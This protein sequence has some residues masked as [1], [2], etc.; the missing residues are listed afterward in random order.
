MKPFRKLNKY[1]R[2]SICRRIALSWLHFAAEKIAE[3]KD[4]AKLSKCAREYVIGEISEWETYEMPASPMIT[5]M[6]NQTLREAMEMINSPRF[7]TV[8]AYF[9]IRTESGWRPEVKPLN[10]DRFP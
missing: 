8:K 6:V 4:P 3:G 9:T 10:P 1:E 7:A 2:D 5:R